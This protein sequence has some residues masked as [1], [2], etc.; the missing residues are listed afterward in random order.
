MFYNS[1]FIDADGLNEFIINRSQHD[2]H[3][4]GTQSL[5]R[6][7]VEEETR[8][9]EI[10]ANIRN[11]TFSIENYKLLE[12][13]ISS[14]IFPRLTSITIDDNC[15]K[16]IIRFIL[17]GLEKLKNLKIG[18]GCVSNLY[19]GSN[20]GR[21]R[22][23]N[24]PNLCL[25]GIGDGSMQGYKYFE[26]SNVPSLQS[27][28]I[29][30]KC[31]R[32]VGIL[33]LNGLEKLNSLSIGHDCMSSLYNQHDEYRFSLAN[34]PNLCRLYIGGRSMHNFATFELSKLNSYQSIHMNDNT[35]SNVKRFVV[36]DLD[37][38]K[39]LKLGRDCM[40]S[41][42]N[43]FEDTSFSIANCPNLC[44]IEIGD[45]SM[46]FYKRFELSN[47]NSLES[48][49][50]GNNCFEKTGVFLLDGLEKLKSVVIGDSFGR[51]NLQGDQ[52]FFRITNCPNLDEL[53]IGR[54]SCS[55]YKQ[56][57]LWNVNSLQSIQFGERCFQH[58]NCALKGM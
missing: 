2:V 41:S 35:F 9:C 24:C 38:L 4:K 52:R 20:E 31:F 49:H 19:K 26:L 47:V 18:R 32:Y 1:N 51:R 44:Q 10:P 55:S 40:S 43:Q 3:K 54:D 36:N 48:I 45:G 22:I 37:T 58:A 5:N 13:N 34:C 57:E 7:S 15:I 6:F 28:H 17:N 46:Q 30:N 42:P 21:F 39:S 23:T 8:L 53:K 16:N 29:G 25:I 12:I 27:I 11:L 56:F 14:N 50:F 33:M